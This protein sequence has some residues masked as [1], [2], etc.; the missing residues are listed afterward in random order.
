MLFILIVIVEG[1]HKG[2][3]FNVILDKAYLF[4]K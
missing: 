2:I 3:L 4:P 1:K